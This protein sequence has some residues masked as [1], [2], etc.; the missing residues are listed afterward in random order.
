[1]DSNYE[2]IEFGDFEKMYVKCAESGMG[3]S[4]L[5]FNAETCPIEFIDRL[6]E[7]LDPDVR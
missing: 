7:D 6:I 2:P 1:M 5:V 3:P 4:V